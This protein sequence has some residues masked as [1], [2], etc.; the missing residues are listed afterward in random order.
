MPENTMPSL[1]PLPLDESLSIPKE[2]EK[3]LAKLEPL[4]TPPLISQDT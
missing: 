3:I 1:D 2:L 4:P